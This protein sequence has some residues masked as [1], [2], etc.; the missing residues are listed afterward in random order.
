V[1]LYQARLMAE[2]PD[3]LFGRRLAAGV[4]SSKTLAQVALAACCG[5]DLGEVERC[6]HCGKVIRVRSHVSKAARAPI[7]AWL[8]EDA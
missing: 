5:A 3:D 8:A 1:R 4:H 7:K 6:P 2:I